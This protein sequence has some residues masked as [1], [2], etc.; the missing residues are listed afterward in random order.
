MRLQV[1]QRRAEAPQ[2]RRSSSSTRARSACRSRMSN[3]T[4][5]GTLQQCS[6]PECTACLRQPSTAPVCAVCGKGLGLGLFDW[7]AQGQAHLGP[8]AQTVSSDAL[9]HASESSARLQGAPGA[10]AHY[11]RCSR[12]P[13]GSLFEAEML[14]L[15][16]NR[17]A[18]AHMYDASLIAEQARCLQGAAGAGAYHTCSSRRPAGFSAGTGAAG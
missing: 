17:A 10:G 8:A 1:L 3:W 5:S 7:P 18:K 12:G 13:A 11:T 6:A 9:M 14:R 15:S 4:L 16:L 2:L